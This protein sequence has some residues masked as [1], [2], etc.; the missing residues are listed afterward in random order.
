MRILDLFCKAGGASH[1]YARA[2]WEV[3]GVDREPQPH[4]VFGPENFVQADALE[5]LAQH[6]REYDAIHASPP[7]QYYSK[8]TAIHDRSV[9]PDMVG[10]VRDALVKTGK[11][12]VIENV[13]GAPLVKPILLCGT[14]FNRGVY[15]HRLFESN[16]PITAPLFHPKHQHTTGSHRGYSRNCPVVCVAGHNF[17]PVQAG[18]EMQIGWMN[19]NELAQ[20]IPPVYTEWV[21]NELLRLM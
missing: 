18:R 21:G 2:G 5:Y 4:Y 14:M 12:W 6:G 8:A 11:P 20:A 7:C 9:H 15:R 19:R 17:D 16:L 3:T 13:I 1:G 10:I